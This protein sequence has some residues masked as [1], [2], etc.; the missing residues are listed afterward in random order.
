M[1]ISLNKLYNENF[2]YSR[3]LSLKMLKGSSLISKSSFIIPVLSVCTSSSYTYSIF[4]NQKF[5]FKIKD[6]FFF[7]NLKNNFK[8]IYI[9]YY[10]YCY[11]FKNLKIYVLII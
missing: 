9:F 8:N 1:N 10:Y 3:F 11:F 4:L 2:V 7:F 5:C 6:F